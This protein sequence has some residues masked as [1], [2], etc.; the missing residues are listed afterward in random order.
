MLDNIY[1]MEEKKENKVYEITTRKQLNAIL[2]LNLITV[3]DFS[4]DWCGPCRKIK[5]E[6][7]KLPIKYDNAVFITVDIENAE[8]LSADFHIKALPTFIFMSS[9]G[10]FNRVLGARLDKVTD[11]LDNYDPMKF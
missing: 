4:A 7:H 6:F 11:I 2:E 3:V 10:E 5:P 9:K 8:V 1:R